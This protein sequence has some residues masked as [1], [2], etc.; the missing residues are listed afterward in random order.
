M[1]DWTK[2]KE[3]NVTWHVELQSQLVQGWHLTAV[4][5]WAQVGGEEATKLHQCTHTLHTSNKS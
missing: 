3:C 1:N 2:H 5:I 4:L